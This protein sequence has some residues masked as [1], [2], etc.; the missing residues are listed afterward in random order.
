M[1]VWISAFRLR[2]LPLAL[3]CILVGTFAAKYQGKINYT[4]LGLA[5]LTTIFLQVLSNLAND[6]GDTKNG[7][8][9]DGREGPS[10]AVQT[11]AISLDAMKR[12]LYIFAGLSLVSGVSL[13]KIALADMEIGYSL[14]FLVLGLG[15]IAAAIK[16]TAGKNPYGYMALGDLFV[17]IF[18]GIVGVCGSYYMQTQTFEWILLLPS[19]A[20]G[21]LS[22]A[23]MNLNNMRDMKSDQ[24]AGKKTMAILFGQASRFYHLFLLIAGMASMFTY[25]YLNAQVE[26]Y[27][28]ALAFP[29]FILNAIKVLKVEE[30]KMLDPE[31]KKVALGTFLLSL[32]FS[33]SFLF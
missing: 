23:V 26:Q 25:V 30:L 10:R 17:F 33:I 9:H 18:F 1:K 19:A 13:I 6:Y 20:I 12:A 32:L 24:E 27:V 7:A 3:S 8:D 11:G 2:T 15:A 16:Y 22:T 28:I 5:V 14:F 31:L 4:I 21:F 29:I